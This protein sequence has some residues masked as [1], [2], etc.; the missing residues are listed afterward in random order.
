LLHASRT[1]TKST[2]AA[3]AAVF[4]LAAA[5]VAAL[6]ACD[7]T[8]ATR[9]FAKI[10][11]NADYTPAPGGNFE[12]GSGGWTF[13]GGARIVSGNESL[14][15][16][17]GSI[18]PGSKALSL[19]LGASATSPEFCVDAS[20]PTFRFMARPENALAG[21][22]AIVI[23]RDADGDVTTS[24]FVSSSQTNWSPGGWDASPASPLATKIPLDGPDET[25]AVRLRFVS[26]GNPLA[27]GIGLWGYLTGGT[28]GTTNIDSVMVD[29]YRRG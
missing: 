29:P 2:L 26:T 8:E 6:A 19:P 18:V 10:G 9:A 27:V 13:S 14:G 15:W 5:P 28:V 24:E 16:F 7:P 11:D 21:Y 25:A 4:G 1:I 23:Y 17:R 3:A 22:K 20:H 12:S